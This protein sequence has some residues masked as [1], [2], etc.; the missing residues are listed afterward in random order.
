MCIFNAVPDERNDLKKDQLG[1]KCI[2]GKILSW[3]TA[4]R[5]LGLP[6]S[7]EPKNANTS[8]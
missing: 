6:K 1:Y 5:V 8:K 4:R 3:D 7:E 2:H